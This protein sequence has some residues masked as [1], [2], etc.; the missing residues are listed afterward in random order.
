LAFKLGAKWKVWEQII[1]VPEDKVDLDKT[2]Y[3]Q[4]ER[5]GSRVL[6][7]FLNGTLY[8]AVCGLIG[9]CVTKGLW[10]LLKLT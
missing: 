3:L 6:G 7:R 10:S 5:L 8:N 4:R 1:K 2:Q 9:A